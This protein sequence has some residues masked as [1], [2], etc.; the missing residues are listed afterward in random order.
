MKSHGMDISLTAIKP[1]NKAVTNETAKET[2]KPSDTQ[3][4]ERIVKIRKGSM[5]NLNA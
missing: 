4:K 1:G 2:A 3:S 5:P